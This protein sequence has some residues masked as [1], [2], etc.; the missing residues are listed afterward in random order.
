MLGFKSGTL[1]PQPTSITSVFKLVDPTSRGPADY[2]EWF[3]VVL[4]HP[5][6]VTLAD[7][8]SRWTFLVCSEKT[9]PHWP[10]YYR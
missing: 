6:N 1:A 2:R 7:P 9:K 10:T 3:G 8:E 4:I 5:D